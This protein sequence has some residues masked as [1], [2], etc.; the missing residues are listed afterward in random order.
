MEVEVEGLPPIAETQPG[1]GQSAGA[2]TSSI[3]APT[4]ELLPIIYDVDLCC[5]PND[6]SVYASH[7]CG[8]A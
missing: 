6:S 7:K 5:F 1:A 8:H 4:L 2:G 3:H